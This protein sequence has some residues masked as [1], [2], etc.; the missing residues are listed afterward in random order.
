MSP[1]PTVN[2]ELKVVPTQIVMRIDGRLASLTLSDVL[3]MVNRDGNP[4]SVL[5]LDNGTKEQLPDRKFAGITTKLLADQAREV[6]R[7]SSTPQ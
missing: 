4:V 2:I 1:V 3:D 5:W 7:G 6:E